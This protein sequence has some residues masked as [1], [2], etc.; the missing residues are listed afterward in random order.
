MSGSFSAIAP[1]VGLCDCTEFLLCM[2]GLEQ[3]QV[4]HR[5]CRF[6]IQNGCAPG[7]VIK[8][9]YYKTANEHILHIYRWKYGHKRKFSLRKLSF[10]S[11]GAM[12]PLCLIG[13][14]QESALFPDLIRFVEFGIVLCGC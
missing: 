14:V 5:S 2:A 1:N 12:L 11:F 13:A 8:H 9:S 6:V 7:K 3:M 10:G 4:C